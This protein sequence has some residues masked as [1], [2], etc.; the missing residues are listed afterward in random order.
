MKQ[1]FIFLLLFIAISSSGASF[2]SREINNIVLHS[3][4]GQDFNGSIL[5]SRKGQVIFE[6]YIGYADKEKTKKLTANH[7][8]SPGSVGKE[9]STI[10]IMQLVAQGKLSYRDKITD[11]IEKL[12]AGGEKI[13]VEH[14]LTHTSGLPKVKW[15]RNIHTSDV[16]QQVENSRL[17]FEPGTD[18]LYSNINVVLRALI[19]EKVTGRPFSVYLKESVFDVAGMMHSYQQAT[20]QDVSDLQVYG[21]YPTF[22]LGTTIYVTPMDLLKFESAL[23]HGKLIQLDELK[24]VLTGDRLSGK[25]NHAYFDFGR[26]YKNSQGKLMSWEHDGSNP[27]HHTLKYH[28]F[29]NDYV[30]VLMSSDGNKNTLYKIKKD[31]MSIITD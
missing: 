15:K 29:I 3:I 14:I 23:W 4:D 25:D 10:A 28:D 22:L 18:Y 17:S 21:D 26:F 1:L 5:V 19:V 13:T 7:I 9:F 11:Y 2:A 6:R 12:P 20:E 8:F 27:S 30:V 24:R 16:I 31:L